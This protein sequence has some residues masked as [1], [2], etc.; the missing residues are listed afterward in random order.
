[1]VYYGDYHYQQSLPNGNPGDTYNTTA[2]DSWV[3]E[4]LDY[5]LQATTQVHLL[6]GVNA[7]QAMGT[8]QEDFDTLT[9]IVLNIR[10]SYND[11]GAFFEVEDKFTSWLSV[12]AGGT[13]RSN[14]AAGRQCQPAFRR[15]FDAHPGRHVQ[16]PV[17]SRVSSAQSL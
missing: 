1:M 5:D 8:H 4:E 9:G 12:T 10:Q 11:A 13:G 3:G 7:T 2:Y 15:H 16:G 14:S 6:A 17:W